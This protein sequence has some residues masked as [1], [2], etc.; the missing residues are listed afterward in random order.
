MVNRSAL[1]SK[2]IADYGWLPLTSGDSGLLIG[3]GATVDITRPNAIISA[4]ADAAAAAASAY[5]A[6][7]DP[8]FAP[9]AAGSRMI[10]PLKILTAEEWNS[11]PM[12]RCG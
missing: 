9:G 5:A 8:Q 10:A 11:L 12:R 4:N 7:G 1:H 6:T 2:C 3:S